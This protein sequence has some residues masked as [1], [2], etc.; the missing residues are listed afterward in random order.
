M[1]WAGQEREKESVQQVH[2]SG[3]SNNLKTQ[4]KKYEN[5]AIHT[6][7]GNVTFAKRVM[8]T[9]KIPTIGKEPSAI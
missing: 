3:G 1:L 9:G 8:L 2:H 5:Y 6:C 4:S 7:K